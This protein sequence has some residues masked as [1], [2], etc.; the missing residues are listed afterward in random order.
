MIFLQKKIASES[1]DFHRLMKAALWD[2]CA[3]QRR[4]AISRLTSSLS[5]GDNRLTFAAEVFSSG[6]SDF[7][8]RIS[9]ISK[10]CAICRS[11]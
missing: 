8:R 5:S 1:S 2:L 9:G 11:G 6:V 3:I 10:T 4:C 7:L